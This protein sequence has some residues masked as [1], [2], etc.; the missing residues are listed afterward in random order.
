MK[1]YSKNIFIEGI[2]VVQG[3]EAEAIALDFQN[4]LRS[5]GLKGVCY[6]TGM[7]CGAWS[8]DV[9]VMPEWDKKPYFQKKCLGDHIISRQYGYFASGKKN[10]I[11]QDVLRYMREKK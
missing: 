9:Y 10:E 8:L 2:P 7:K 4:F 6:R 11:I 3:T 5:K 1:D